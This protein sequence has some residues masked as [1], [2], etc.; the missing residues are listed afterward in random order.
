MELIIIKK[1]TTIKQQII[2]FFRLYKTWK[3]QKKNKCHFIGYFLALISYGDVDID[4]NGDPFCF[5]FKKEK[6][7]AKENINILYNSKDNKQLQKH[8][9]TE[10]Q[11][12]YQSKDRNDSEPNRHQI[13]L[14]IDHDDTKIVEDGILFG[15]FYSVR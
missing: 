4:V 5:L 13:V 8:V 15:L 6:N 14:N 10:K 3:Q 2:Y 11:S 1:K 9:I 12:M 7:K